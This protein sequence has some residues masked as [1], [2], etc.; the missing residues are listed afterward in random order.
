MMY[1]KILGTLKETSMEASPYSYFS[2]TRKYG[3][4]EM[5]DDT[6]A[7]FFSKEFKHQVADYI[8]PI[9][10]LTGTES[11]DYVRCVLVDRLGNDRVADISALAISSDPLFVG[12]ALNSVFGFKVYNG[13][14]DVFARALTIL[15]LEP[16]ASS[17]E[18]SEESDA[19]ASDSSGVFIYETVDGY[20][21]NGEVEYDTRTYKY[22]DYYHIVDPAKRFL[23]DWAADTASTTEDTDAGEVVSGDDG[24][25]G[26]ADAPDDGSAAD[27]EDTG[28]DSG[29]TVDSVPDPELVIHFGYKDV[30]K[31]RPALV[32]ASEDEE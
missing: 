10:V 26:A 11:G 17:T 21:L 9:G 19:A 8:K 27:G 30:Y 29:S 1:C 12:Q 23:S 13:L 31:F 6:H 7:K 15:R 32:D 18:P 25:A 2:L 20:P 3:L 5:W 28:S 4:R 16:A 14:Y 22:I 24:G